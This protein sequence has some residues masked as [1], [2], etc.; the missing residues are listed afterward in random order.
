[1]QT[2]LSRQNTS[3]SY[4]GSLSHSAPPH[5]SPG[6]LSFPRVSGAGREHTFHFLSS[7]QA[8]PWHSSQAQVG[9]AQQAAAAIPALWTSCA[10]YTS[11]ATPSPLRGFIWTLFT[12]SLPCEQASGLRD[13]CSQGGENKVIRVPTYSMLQV[14]EQPTKTYRVIQDSVP[15]TLSLLPSKSPTVSN[16]GLTISA[17]DTQCQGSSPLQ[18][19]KRGISAAPH[20]T[21]PPLDTRRESAFQQR[22]YTWVFRMQSF[23][24][25][26]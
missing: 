8:G 10:S 13:F 26:C 22:L 15:L 6:V 25:H 18:L 14:V 4:T 17:S 16:S 24:N 5:L 7:P 21:A 23:L 12:S 20:S 11:N 1:M 3:R 2:E 19:H 9:G